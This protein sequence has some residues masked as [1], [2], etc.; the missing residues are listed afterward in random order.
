VLQRS[1]VLVGDY[2]LYMV[3]AVH[4][5]L[6]SFWTI[7]EYFNLSLIIATFKLSYC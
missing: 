1:E 3:S 2:M 7:K 4:F 6:I 5:M